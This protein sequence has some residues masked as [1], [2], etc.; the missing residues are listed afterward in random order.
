MGLPAHLRLAGFVLGA[1][2]RLDGPGLGRHA[3]ME[4]G[5]VAHLDV[6]REIHMQRVMGEQL[7]SVERVVQLDDRVSQEQQ[8]HHHPLQVHGRFS[9]HTQNNVSLSVAGISENLLVARTLPKPAHSYN[10]TASACVYHRPAGERS[11]C[12][13]SIT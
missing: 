8:R 6:R 5:A 2:L 13:V 10:A 4:I 7:T 3:D 12:S 11:W 1:I 9:P